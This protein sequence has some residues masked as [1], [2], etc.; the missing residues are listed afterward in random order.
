MATYGLTELAEGYGFIAV[1]AAGLVLR[2]S[3]SKHEFHVK[4]HDFVQSIEHALT[5]ILLIGLG[6]AI[7]ALLPSLDWTGAVIGCGLVFVVRPVSGWVSL[8]GA[9]ARRRERIVVAFYGVRGIGSIYYLGYAGSHMELVNEA[10]LWA[11]V[12]FTILVS[13]I[14]HGFTAGLA[15]E[16]ATGEAAAKRSMT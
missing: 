1:F 9:M 15:V 12:A 3:E 6:A 5:A 8:A 2:R 7:P 13:T 4:L 11:T 10:Q 14:V 16:N